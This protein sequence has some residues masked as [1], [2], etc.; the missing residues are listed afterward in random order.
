MRQPQKLRS[1]YTLSL[2]ASSRCGGGKT[3]FWDETLDDVPDQATWRT[4]ATGCAAFKVADDITSLGAWAATPTT[5]T[6]RSASTAPLWC[7]TP[8]ACGFTV[9]SRY[10]STTRAEAT[11]STTPVQASPFQNPTPRQATWS[12]THNLNVVRSSSL[13]HRLTLGSPRLSSSGLVA[14]HRRTRVPEQKG[15][16]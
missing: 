5:P 7:L 3:I 16:A 10:R 13:Q 8:P 14:P 4:G 6:R 1:F 15:K 2:R 12:T 11:I 9:W